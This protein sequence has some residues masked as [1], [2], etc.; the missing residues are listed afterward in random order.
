MAPERAGCAL[1]YSLSRME[2]ESRRR[3][4]ERRLTELFR[5]RADAL[6]PKEIAASREFHL[7]HWLRIAEEAIRHDHRK[8]FYEALAPQLESLLACSDENVS[9]ELLAAIRKDLSFMEGHVQAFR[10]VLAALEQVR[11]ARP[12]ARAAKA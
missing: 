8:L 3:Q 5:S 6:D 12:K 10:A 9:P 7:A 11:S 1:K 4:A 2:S